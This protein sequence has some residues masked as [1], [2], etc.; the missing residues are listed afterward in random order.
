MEKLE[1]R[2]LLLS[3]EEKGRES[4]KFNLRGKEV[5]VDVVQL[6]LKERDAIQNNSTLNDDFTRNSHEIVVLTVIASTCYVGTDER[7]F[8]QKDFKDLYE[9]ISGGYVED[10]AEKAIELSAVDEDEVKKN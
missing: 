2:E 3:G 6:S 4:V 8:T 7:I 5:E 1:L 9:L 10:L